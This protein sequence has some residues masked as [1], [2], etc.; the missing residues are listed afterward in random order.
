MTITHFQESVG[1]QAERLEVTP[2]LIRLRRKTLVSLLENKPLP[3]DTP[4]FLLNATADDMMSALALMPVQT[5][6]EEDDGEE[7]VLWLVPSTAPPC[8]NLLTW[9]ST[10]VQCGRQLK[11]FMVPNLATCQ[12]P[13]GYMRKGKGTISPR[14][15]PSCH[16]P[17]SFHHY[18]QKRQRQAHH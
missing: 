17:A 2:N 15:W 4:K 6:K 14:S 16:G 8:R 12:L 5:A 18:S 10:H 11:S 13:Y 1:Q 3:A 9:H 7:K